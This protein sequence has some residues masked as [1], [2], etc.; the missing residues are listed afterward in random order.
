LTL[1]LKGPNSRALESKKLCF[2][3]YMGSG[4]S[5]LGRL[6]ARKLDWSF[7][8]L[9]QFI[10]ERNGLSIPEI[11]DKHGEDHFRKLEREALLFLLKEPDPLLISCGGGSPIYEDNMDHM[12][13]MAICVHLKA[14]EHLLYDRL[15]SS[16]SNRPLIRNMNEA[17]LRAYIK[18][19]LAE[20]EAQYQRAQL[21][22]N[23]ANAKSNQE[24]LI[25]K[26]RSYLR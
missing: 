26:I 16:K 22:L 24:D 8:D 14:D 15:K 18:S 1:S 2:L 25:Q 11:F 12:I 5:T 6:V 19:S 9:D 10:E 3:G 4:K 13:S 7:I 23:A 21:T 17:E 20:R